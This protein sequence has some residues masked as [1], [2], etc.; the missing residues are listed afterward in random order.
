MFVNNPEFPI[1]AAKTALFKLRLCKVASRHPRSLDLSLRFRLVNQGHQLDV[2][3]EIN[4][5]DAGIGTTRRRR[6]T[7]IN[8]K[9][10]VEKVIVHAEDWRIAF[11]NLLISQTEWMKSKTKVVNQNQFNA[12]LRDLWIAYLPKNSGKKLVAWKS[13]VFIG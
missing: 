2:N 11:N 8:R 13:L 9:K 5:N 3:E 4:E 6:K 10:T 12:I 7:H 1:Y